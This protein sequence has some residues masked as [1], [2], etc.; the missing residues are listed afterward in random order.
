MKLSKLSFF[1][2]IVPFLVGLWTLAVI[3]G[4]LPMAHGVWTPEGQEAFKAEQR[5]QRTQALFTDVFQK[6]HI[7]PSFAWVTRDGNHQSSGEATLVWS[8]QKGACTMEVDPALARSLWGGNAFGPALDFVSLHE[9]AHCLYYADQRPDWKG[10]G[11]KGTISEAL[12][13][14]ML[15]AESFTERIERP[16]YLLQSHEVYADAFAALSLAYEGVSM[17]ELQKVH[18]L[19]DDMAMDQDHR[20]AGQVATTLQTAYKARTPPREYARREAARFLLEQ[21]NLRYFLETASTPDMQR[22]VVSA[23]CGWARLYETTQG[24]KNLPLWPVEHPLIGRIASAE[25][26][27]FPGFSIASYTISRIGSLA[28]DEQRCER[29]AMQKIRAVL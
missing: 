17:D 7:V 26:H 13:N 23:W 11:Y 3:V 22:Y 1:E 5:V 19:R 15:L 18:T 8:G 20:A 21:S 12:L 29:E 24:E 6:G 9:W 4:S 10:A 25:E 2:H 28:N 14:E 27:I 16:N